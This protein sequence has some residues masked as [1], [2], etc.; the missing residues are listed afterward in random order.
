[1]KTAVEIEH[2]PTPEAVTTRKPAL[3]ALTGL[4]TLLALNIVLFHFTPSH[5]H[6]LYPVIDNAYV[7]VGFF[8]LISGFIL[9]YNYSDRA[10]TLSPR[11]FYLARFS[12]IYPTYALALT[13]S[14]P[15]MLGEYKAR[16]HREFWEG[17]FLTPLTMQGW[18][19]SL[20][21]YWNTVGWT[22]SA[23]VALYL[24]FPFL[25]RQ[26]ATRG[27]R[28]NTPA[29][30]IAAM[31]VLWVIGITPHL[32]YLFTNPDHIVGHIDRFSSGY[33]L[34]TLK[35]TP[36]PY[37]CTFLNGMLL[38]RLH[39]T[40]NLSRRQRFLVAAAALF[41]LWLFFETIV[42]QMPYV[43]MHGSLMMPFF[44]AL[45]LGLSGPNSIASAFSWRP[46]VLLGETTFALY[47][48]HFN[49]FVLIHLYHI[50][51]RLHVAAYDP[52]ISYAALIAM[53]F[54]TLHWIERPAHRYLRGRLLPRPKPAA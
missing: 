5:L 23:E 40:L 30:L 36:P 44:A 21:T 54:A 17:L 14:I 49:G 46:L 31:L 38:S 16:S 45:I 51:E 25:L 12:R 19:A 9:S 41:G 7:F 1:M 8:F 2:A 20:A 37:L 39:A 43:L 13:L 22:I 11:Q 28:L 15:L 10:L 50:P 34:R 27:A 24:A 32:F 42:R 18:S 26:F 33:W 35:Y 29:K 47:L 52:W 48:L 3:P 6:Y 4:R 53:A